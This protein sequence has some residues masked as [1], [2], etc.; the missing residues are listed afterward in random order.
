MTDDTG[1]VMWTV[2]ARPSD[3]PDDYVA[4]KWVV[5]ASGVVKTENLRIATSL[6]M[7]REDMRGMGLTQM[8]RH[9]SDDPVIVETWI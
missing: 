6:E 9:P 1:L 8:P 2:Y 3:F 7:I 5:D 4:R